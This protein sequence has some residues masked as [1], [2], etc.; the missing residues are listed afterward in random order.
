MGF[1]NRLRGGIIAD[2]RPWAAAR[3]LTFAGETPLLGIAFEPVQD[4]QANVC[5]GKLPDGRLGAVAHEFSPSS[6]DRESGGTRTMTQTRAATRVP[7]AVGALRRFVLTNSR[8]LQS[9][10]GPGQRELDAYALGG[11][12]GWAMTGAPGIDEALLRTLLTN[13]LGDGLRAYEAPAELRYAYGTLTLTRDRAYLED[14]DLD[15]HVHALCAMADA[16][17][18]AALAAAQPLPFETELP[19]PGWL[20]E[21]VPAGPDVRRAGPFAMVVGTTG[22]P[23][24]ETAAFDE[25]PYAALRAGILKLRGDAALEDPLA[26]HEAFPTVPVP[27]HAVAVYRRGAARVV[28]HTEGHVSRGA[29]A[30]LLPVDAPDHP[31]PISTEAGVLSVAV[32]DGLMAAWM[33]REGPE[34]GDRIALIAR[35]ARTVADQ[36][37]WMTGADCDALDRG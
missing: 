21:A 10:P 31:A 17:S 4:Q 18:R 11:P 15:Q 22:L 29:T 9:R 19:A 23:A 26:Y 8:E 2:L 35:E 16:L 34:T 7:E 3:H 20:D 5:F 37:G 33:H 30:V 14:A 24:Q 28:L 27:G 36:Q 13:G 25:P 12:H 32:R 6:G 1:L